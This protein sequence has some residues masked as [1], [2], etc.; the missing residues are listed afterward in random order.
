MPKVLVVPADV[1]GNAPGVRRPAV[2]SRNDTAVVDTNSAFEISPL[3]T[4]VEVA[5]D[6]KVQIG[7]RMTAELAVEIKRML[8]PRV[9]G[10]PKVRVGIDV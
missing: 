2:R 9:G 1:N 4:M 10:A 6:V 5:F 8:F 7:A 3:V